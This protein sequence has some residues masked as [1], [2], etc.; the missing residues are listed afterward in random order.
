M[1]L[2]LIG[3][4]LIGG[5]LLGAYEHGASNRKMLLPALPGAGIGLVAWFVVFVIASICGH[6]GGPSINVWQAL[7][8]IASNHGRPVYVKTQGDDSIDKYRYMAKGKVGYKEDTSSAPV[9]FVKSDNPRRLRVCNLHHNP[10]WS[11]WPFKWD[12]KPHVSC[13]DET[14]EVFYV[15][16]GR[17]N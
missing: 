3:L 10:A 5:L 16:T 12:T 15:P 6:I 2:V 4:G 17:A 9:E 11:V 13:I 8:P 14:T 7:H 1:M